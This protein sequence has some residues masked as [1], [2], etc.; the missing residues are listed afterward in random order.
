MKYFLRILLVIVLA[1][2]VITGVYY[3]TKEKTAP[4]PE[5]LTTASK[6]AVTERNANKKLVA[7][8]EDEKIYLYVSDDAVILDFKGTQYEYTDWGENFAVEKPEMYYNHFDYDDEKELVIK[9]VDG[10]N[11]NNETV[12][13]VFYLDPVV[14]DNGKKDFVV[15]LFNRDSWLK[16]IDRDVKAEVSQLKSSKKTGQFVLD[17][18]NNVIN[19][20][21]ETGITKNKHVGY[22]KVLQDKKGNYLTIDKW[23]KGN[24]EYI[25]TDDGIIKIN[26]PIIISFKNSKETQNCGY[27]TLELR[28]GKSYSKYITDKSLSF[29]P[30]DEYKISD[31]RTADNKKW[32]YTENN[33]NTSIP[34]KK[35]INWIKY[36]PAFDKTITTQT[37][38]FSTK[39]SDI[40]CVE[41]MTINQNGITMVAK[42]SISFS[43]SASSGEF[44]VIINSGSKN[45]YEI[46]LSGSVSKNKAGKEVLK[47]NF[48]K[49]YPQSEINSIIINYGTK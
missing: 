11:N 31:P 22:F 34:T 37:I 14:N 49:A 16:L 29:K 15:V 40:N 41:E 2:A 47:I 3:T 45:E 42:K 17:Y 4:T 6:P 9:A 12:Y 21:I 10:I 19:Y 32:S 38:D 23:Q 30:A 13:N 26:V 33:L 48:D 25:I 5:F 18:I 35:V 27:L 43:N 36:Q 20:D 44:S 8:I 46:S 1:V 28:V 39:E 24:G 7:S